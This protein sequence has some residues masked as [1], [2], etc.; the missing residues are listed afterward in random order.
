[1]G[2]PP[3]RILIIVIGIVIIVVAARLGIKGVQKKFT[4][5][6]AGGVGAGVIRLNPE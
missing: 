4:Q 5:D 6:L 1:M 3:S 2:T